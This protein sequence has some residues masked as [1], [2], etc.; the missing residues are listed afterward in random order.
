MKTLRSWIPWQRLL[1]QPCKL[2]LIA[3]RY[4]SLLPAASGMIPSESTLVVVGDPWAPQI[5]SFEP[6]AGHTGTVVRINGSRFSTIEGQ[7]IVDFNLAGGRNICKYTAFHPAA[8]IFRQ[9]LRANQFHCIATD[10]KVDTTAG[11]G[12][13]CLYT[14]WRVP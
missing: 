1:W 9:R 14:D 2:F 10:C 11:T 3:A 12:N 5:T 4:R 8:D 13:V 7:N 6:R